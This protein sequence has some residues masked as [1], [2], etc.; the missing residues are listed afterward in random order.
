MITQ[1]K[2]IALFIAVIFVLVIMLSAWSPPAGNQQKGSLA[3][4]AVSADAD[5]GEPRVSLTSDEAS[6]GAGPDGSFQLNQVTTGTA[7]TTFNAGWN[8]IGLSL[9][10]GTPYTA[11]SLGNEINDQGGTA[12][13]VQHWDGSGWETHQ[14]GLPFGDFPLALAEGY[15][16]LAETASDWTLEGSPVDPQALDLNAGWNLIT[17][18]VAG[19]TA[20]SLGQDVND[21]GGSATIVQHWD[22]SG[23]ET[24]QIGLPFGDF[25]IEAGQGYFVRCDSPSTWT[26]TSP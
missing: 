8:L 17:I 26:P 4:G 13:I 9:D 21:Q 3:V 7:V 23:W 15:F 2:T 20:E 1:I 24:H 19:Y 11:E 6:I 10:P 14:I 5:P 16:V 22:G 12:T 18:P 25:S